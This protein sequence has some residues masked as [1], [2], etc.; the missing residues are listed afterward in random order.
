MSISPSTVA[1]VAGASRGVGRGVALALGEAG[2]TVYVTGRT[3]KSA[4]RRD[5]SGSIDETAAEVSRRGGHGIAVQTD[6]A[7]VEDV[8]ALAEAVRQRDGRLDV[9]VL[10]VGG[11]GGAA[12]P[13]WEQP[14][15]RW[16]TTVRARVWSALVTLRFLA[17]LLLEASGLAVT[18]TEAPEDGEPAFDGVARAGLSEVAAGLARDAK[19][20]GVTSVALTTGLVR[21]ERV[22]AAFG[23]TERRWAR[24]PALADSRS[25]LDVGRV[26]VALA[27]DPARFA[28]TGQ[29]LRVDDL[30][31]EYLAARA[32]L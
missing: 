1:L 11:A 26:V 31:A 3:L 30:A 17:P 5:V 22:L 8:R 16:D 27:A 6:H 14:L 2:A 20:W 24:E 7:R 19:P 28:R 25:P 21:T 15:A 12:G 13:L 9:L 4:R 10:A 29:T 18:L 23:T 32:E